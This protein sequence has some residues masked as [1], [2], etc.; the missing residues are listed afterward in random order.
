MSSEAGLTGPEAERVVASLRPH[1]RAL[2]FPSLVLIGAAGAMPYFSGSF[3]EEWQNL[4]V[5]AGGL[6]AIV[7]FWMLP[8]MSWLATRYVITT[9]RLVLRHGLFVRTRQ[10]LLHSR[11]YDVSVRK[12]AVQ[13]LF[14]SGNV[15]IN[16]GLD[17]PVV[18]RDAP[19]A[20]LVQGTL[21]DLMENSINPIAA[22]RQAEQS[23]AADESSAWGPR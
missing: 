4:A 10:E 22:R 9:R 13:A 14:G 15:I 1:G 6:I 5:L 12:N 20:D 8:M 23:G 18:M 19:S 11:G 7:L 2:F 21:H 3:A 17:N 16:V